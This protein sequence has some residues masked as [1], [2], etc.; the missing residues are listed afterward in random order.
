[1]YART[2]DFPIRRASQQES[3]LPELNRVASHNLSFLRAIRRNH[4][5]KQKR[6]GCYRTYSL[7]APALLICVRNLYTRT[8]F[9]AV[10]CYDLTCS[11]SHQIVP[12]EVS[13][14][15]HYIYLAR[16]PFIP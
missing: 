2:F 13:L 16:I 4:T 5:T 9:A 6:A 14:Q 1:M 12:A 11:L 15:S 10:P 8:I 3:G 7:V